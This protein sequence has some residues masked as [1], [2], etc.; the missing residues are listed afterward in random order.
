M[1]RFSHL[2]SLF[3]GLFSLICIPVISDAITGTLSEVDPMCSANFVF[4]RKLYLGM[5]FAQT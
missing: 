5:E 2:T 4:Y 3:I 1:K